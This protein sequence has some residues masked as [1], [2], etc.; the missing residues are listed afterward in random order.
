MNYGIDNAQ[1]AMVGYAEAGLQVQQNITVGENIDN[2]IAQMQAEIARLEASKIELAPLLGMKI[3][4]I[5]EA[6]N[7]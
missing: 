5:R 3:R 1:K 6:M 4:D 2:K 7:Y